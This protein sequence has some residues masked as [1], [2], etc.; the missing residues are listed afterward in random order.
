VGELRGGVRFFGINIFPREKGVL[1]KKKSPEK[2]SREKT[3]WLCLDA[4]KRK[5]GAREHHADATTVVMARA[6]EG[7]ESCGLI[8]AVPP[9]ATH[10]YIF[11][12][13]VENVCWRECRKS[14]VSRGIQLYMLH[15][16][17]VGAVNLVL[18]SFPPNC[19]YKNRHNLV[20]LL[21]LLQ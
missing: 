8:I 10:T 14:A 5:E 19:R 7:A 4:A 21:F 6:Q 1:L 15:L 16:P 11:T 20:G 12:R 2:S 18:F 13:T 9:R 17:S 3:G